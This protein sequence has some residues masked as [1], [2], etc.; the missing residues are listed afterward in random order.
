MESSE[1]PEILIRKFLIKSEANHELYLP[2]SFDIFEIERVLRRYVDSENPNLNYLQAIVIE[3]SSSECPISDRLI[4]NAKNKCE[5]IQ[6]TLFK[7]GGNAFKIVVSF[8]NNSD[9]VTE[10]RNGSEIKYIC[11]WLKWYLE[12]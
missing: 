6:R 10:K 11:G 5:E 4:M 7:D 12:S 9:L 1:F 8:E 2:A 3:Q